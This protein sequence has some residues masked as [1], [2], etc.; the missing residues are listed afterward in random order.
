[1][2]AKVMTMGGKVELSKGRWN[3]KRR[4]WVTTHFSQGIKPHFSQKA[5]KYKEC[6][7][8]SFQI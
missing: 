8:F 6:I 2:F 5:L 3:L 1:M 4:M 7:A